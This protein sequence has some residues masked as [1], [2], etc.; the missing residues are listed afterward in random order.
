MKTRTTSELLAEYATIRDRQEAMAVEDAVAE[1]TKTTWK[2]RLGLVG[3][4]YM[5][6]DIL[7]HVI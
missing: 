3:A 5:I 2:H 7:I 1:A 6:L 4:I